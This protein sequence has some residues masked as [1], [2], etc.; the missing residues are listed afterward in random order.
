MFKK[1]L[2]LFYNLTRR[3]RPNKEVLFEVSCTE[4][5]SHFSYILVARGSIVDSGNVNVFNKQKTSF[6]YRLLP[7][8]AP[9][10]KLIVSYTNKEFLIFDELD[11]DFDVFNNDVSN[12]G[13]FVRKV[14]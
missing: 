12:W 2:T 4:R 3:V 13:Y 14:V 9:K 10:A 8:L 6:R 5:I 7:Q 11:L 1:S